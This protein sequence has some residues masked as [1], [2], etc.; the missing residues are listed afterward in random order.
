[1][2]YSKKS[3][4]NSR[5]NLK[6]SSKRKTRMNN[7]RRSKKANNK[8]VMKGG[9][10]DTPFDVQRL[11][12]LVSLLNRIQP[13]NLLTSEY[14]EIFVVRQLINTYKGLIRN[15]SLQFDSPLERGT[16]RER[17]IQRETAMHRIITDLS[18]SVVHLE[19]ENTFVS[20]NVNRDIY[21][22]ICQLIIFYSLI[23][24]TTKDLLTQEQLSSKLTTTDEY[25][26]N[27]SFNGLRSLNVNQEVGVIDSIKRH[28]TILGLTRSISS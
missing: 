24:Y 26:Y 15:F 13:I 7:A 21:G 1:M 25:L 22:S 6:K 27:N 12:D 11:N 3:K 10:H 5:M 28:L 18:K 2:V 23:Y 14:E 9:F 8:L 17:D 16:Q 19:Q 4:R 20:S